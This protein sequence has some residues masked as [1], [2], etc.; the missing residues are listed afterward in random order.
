MDESFSTHPPVTN[1][2]RVTI[3]SEWGK[4]R[5][6]DVPNSALF[7]LA[8]N[9]FG[10]EEIL[11]M[12]DVLL[13]G[14]LTLGEKVNAAEHE[15]SRITKAPFA[16]MVNS[17]SS[18]NLLAVAA[19]TNKLRKVHCE[20][21][22]EVMVPAVC[23]STSV[24]PLL[25]CGLKPI[26]VDVDPKTF[27]VDV[28]ELE[29][30]MTPRVKAIMAVHVLGNATCMKELLSFVTKHKLMLIE[31]TCESLGTFIRDG[32]K[33]RML[34]TYGDFGTYSFYF[35]HHITSGEGGMVVCKTEEDYNLVRCLR[36]HGWTRHLTNREEMEVTYPDIDP[37][38]LFVN[39]GFN[40]RPMEVQGA[41]LSVQLIKLAEYNACRRDNFSRIRSSLHADS[42]FSKYMSLMEA[43]EGTDP[44]W[45]GI[46]A[47]LH[48]SFAHQL[49]EYL[50]F[51]GEHGIE[52][53]PI[54]SGNFT[55]QPCI[56]TYCRGENPEN[57]PGAD[58]LHTRGFFIGVHQ[59]PISDATISK[60]VDLMLSFPFK[61]QRVVLVT[62]SDGMLGRYVQKEV[63]HQDDPTQWIWV[64]RRDGDLCELSDVEHLFKKHQ[65]THVLHLAAKL[66]SIQ[67]MTKKPVDFW[68][69]NVTINNNIL[70]T[71][72]K[73][74]TWIGPIKVVSVLSTV[75][76]PRDAIFPVGSTAEELF[77]GHLHEAAESYAFAKRAL[78]QLSG[79]YRKQHGASF[80]S[81]LP[82]NFFGAYGDFHPTTAPLV[83]SLI[84]KAEVAMKNGELLR[85]MGTGNPERQVMFAAD[86]A[87]VTL[88][89][90]DH[91]EDTLPLIVAG[92]ELSIRNIAELVCE[93]TGFTGGIEFDIEATDG[94][95]RRTADTTQFSLL[96][97]N[98]KFTPL[99]DA[100]KETVLWYRE[101]P[102]QS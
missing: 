51:L 21:G 7:P 83:N 12:T 87:R 69:D 25:Q 38:F 101:R 33:T 97:P 78:A 64:T 3:A 6:A 75:M 66:A 22:D 27:N 18:A 24:F 93:A 94:P 102:D 58:V 98:F 61:I 59:V 100:I 50:D 36:A 16:V 76:F 9:P 72:H 32:E 4:R 2:W 23:W 20:I 63:E 28:S 67:E 42:R 65:P 52:N 49:R 73:F 77:G 45:F 30:R 31:D 79:W 81:I 82:G 60:L 53:R 70:R 74:Q 35:S 71:A 57:Y 37:R 47:L 56:A 84:A 92:E 44:A 5:A 96:C 10:V 91:F 54:I 62:G 99:L 43:S 85:V 55:R 34:G 29:K 48:R 95:F 40:L 1:D 88:W 8:M 80:V 68:L 46:G 19:I 90:L 86:L 41:M 89:S 11:A 17:G 15:F 13:S 26:F 14:R 39:M